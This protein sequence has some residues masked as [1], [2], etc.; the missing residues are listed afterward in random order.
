MGEMQH[1]MRLP[2]YK[3]QVPSSKQTGFQPPF[4]REPLSLTP[5]QVKVILTERDKLAAKE[6]MHDWDIAFEISAKLNKG[7]SNSIMHSAVF[8]AIQLLVDEGKLNQNPNPVPA[9]QQGSI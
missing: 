8:R 9:P 1:N 3:R 2:Q 5:R 6:G 4:T 7:V